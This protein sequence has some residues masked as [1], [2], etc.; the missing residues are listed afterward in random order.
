[1]EISNIPL[2]AMC[3]VFGSNEAGI[4]GAGAAQYAYKKRG[5]VYY[6]G[7]G[8]AGNSFAIPTKD[9]KIRTLPLPI[10][11]IYVSRFIAYAHIEK[12]MIFQVTCIGCGLAGLDHA[13]VAPMFNDAPD[14]CFF[15]EVWGAFIDAPG[16][17][18]WGTF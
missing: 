5:A 13:D 3:F 2:D 18:Y 14:N 7:F 9:W 12:N 1:M 8:P 11:E 6:H 4:H 15:D 10:I 17:Q 16:R